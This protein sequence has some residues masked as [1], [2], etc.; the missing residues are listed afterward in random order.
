MPFKVAAR[1]ILQLGSELISSDGVAFYELIKNAFDAGTRDGVRIDLVIRIPH[2]RYRELKALVA[3]GSSR[4]SRETRS[5]IL[6]AIDKTA[7]RVDSLTRRIDQAETREQLTEALE[8]ANY[9]RFRDSGEGMSRQQLQTVYL[10]IGTHARLEQR[11][12][13]HSDRPILGEKGIGRLSAMRLGMRLRVRTSRTGERRWNLLNI[14]WKDFSE[15][16]EDLIDDV[17]VQPEDGPDKEDPTESG[18]TIRISD[19]NDEWTLPKLKEIARLEFSRLMD[20]F[21]RPQVRL[22]FRFNDE[23]VP[24]P[25]IN[26]LLFDHADAYIHAEVGEQSDGS[27]ELRGEIVYNL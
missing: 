9:I 3:S 25:P 13:G 5:A 12:K 23:P 8:S 27:V 16:V 2:K 18:T 19:L 17:P 24:I 21:S 6:Q 15:D 7:P 4:P 20:P 1:T 11:S 26:K 22:F 10:T 14:D